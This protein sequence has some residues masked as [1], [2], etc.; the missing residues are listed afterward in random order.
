MEAIIRNDSIK[1]A[2]CAMINKLIYAPGRVLKTYLKATGTGFPVMPRIMLEE[3][4]EE[5]FEKTVTRITVISRTEIAFDLV[6]DLSL[7]ETL[8]SVPVNGV[9]YR[10]RPIPRSFTS[11][12]FIDHY[13]DPKVQAEYVYNLIKERPCQQY[14]PSSRK[15]KYCTVPG[16]PSRC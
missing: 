8:G 3:F 16:R 13:D 11:P 1:T 5:L 10:S 15:E 9:T 14:L 2:F 6:C 12:K 7:R 4:D